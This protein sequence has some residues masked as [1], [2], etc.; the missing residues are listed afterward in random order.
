M[1]ARSCNCC[2]SCR[3]RRQRQVRRSHGRNCSSCCRGSSSG[4]LDET[5]LRTLRGYVGVQSI[6]T[7]KD[8]PTQGIV[9]RL[10]RRL[11]AI[12]RRARQA[13]A[14]A[15]L[16]GRRPRSRR[17]RPE[18]ARP[19]TR[20]GG[21]LRARQG[22]RRQARFRRP[23]VSRQGAAHRS[24]RMPRSASGSRPSCG[25]CWSTNFRTPTRLQVELVQALCGDVAD[26]KLFFV[27][28]MNQSIYRFR[29][30][31]PDVFLDLRRAG[32]RAGP[33]AAHAKLPQPAGDAQLRQRAVRRTLSA[34]DYKP[35]Q[36]Q[37]AANHRR[38]GDRVSLD[39]H[40]ATSVK[41]A[42]RT[43][44]ASRKP[45]ASPAACANSSRAKNRS[46]PTPKPMAASAPCSSATSPSC[47]AR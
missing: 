19:G 34:T 28:D 39:A 10:P 14:E 18:A 17:A 37:S 41:P 23:A 36:P 1:S 29:G 31:Q 5:E 22:P 11:Q 7:A 40:A 32:S 27:G 15:V 6:C 30:A 33:I 21:S 26:G 3:R 9:R 45:A 16:A 43:T 46:L 12:P 44:P 25:C 13:H 2:E 4:E 24:R 8:W 47:S 38:A 35:L 42:A 20:H